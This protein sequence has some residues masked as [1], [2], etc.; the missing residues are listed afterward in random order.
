MKNAKNIIILK[1]E[2][3]DAFFEFSTSIALCF[4]YPPGARAEILYSI[5]SVHFVIDITPAG[6]HKHPLGNQMKN[7]RLIQ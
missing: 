5:A 7:P 2:K 6:M 3:K 4:Q 1:H